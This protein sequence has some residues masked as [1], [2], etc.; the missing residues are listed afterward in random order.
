[1][2]LYFLNYT[3][4]MNYLI[5][6][7]RECPNV[8][9][10]FHEFSL[11]HSRVAASVES[12]IATMQHKNFCVCQRRTLDEFKRVLSVAHASQPVQRADNLGIPQPTVWRVLRHRL[13]FSWVI[14]L[15]HPVLITLLHVSIIRS[16]SGSTLCSLLKLQF[17]NTQWFTSLRWVG[18]VAACR[19]CCV[20][21]VYCSEWAWLW[22]CVVRRTAWDSFPFVG[23][24]IK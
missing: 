13:L 24:L 18:A 14:F 15:N 6:V 20:W 2:H 1:V 3:W 7:E 12:K 23:V 9:R 4:Y 19:V 17:K 11:A 5:S 8:S 21:V 10:I 22:I 16:S